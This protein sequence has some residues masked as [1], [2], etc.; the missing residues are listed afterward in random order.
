MT[1]LEA[2]NNLDTYG[3]KNDYIYPVDYVSKGIPK[4]KI[5]GKDCDKITL[6]FDKDFYKFETLRDCESFLQIISKYAEWNT[7]FED[8]SFEEAMYEL[9]VNEKEIRC[10]DWDDGS[11]LFKSCKGVFESVGSRFPEDLVNYTITEE[12]SKARWEIY[13]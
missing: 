6:G 10:K 2:L 9:M 13:R 12:D 8:F 4:I 11:Y 3:R 7:C 5:S 1:F